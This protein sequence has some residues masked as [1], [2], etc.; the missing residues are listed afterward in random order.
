MNNFLVKI[1][2]FFSYKIFSLEFWFKFQY[3]KIRNRIKK[4]FLKKHGY[5]NSYSFLVRYTKLPYEICKEISFFEDSPILD[6]TRRLGDVKHWKFSP[7]VVFEYSMNYN[8]FSINQFLEEWNIDTKEKFIHLILLLK[9][10]LKNPNTIPNPKIFFLL[11]E[12]FDYKCK[13]NNIY[14]LFGR[15]FGTTFNG[16]SY[17]DFQEI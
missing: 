1:I 13:F 2:Q 16:T 8:Y 9:N 6:F 12:K 3:I 17:N 7:H 4:H 5:I 10:R 14:F 11:N 15:T